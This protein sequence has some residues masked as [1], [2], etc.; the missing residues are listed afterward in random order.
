MYVACHGNKW[1]SGPWRPSCIEL[2]ACTFNFQHG[3]VHVRRML[4]VNKKKKK[5]S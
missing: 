1:Q 4:R 2:N 3:N 5:K